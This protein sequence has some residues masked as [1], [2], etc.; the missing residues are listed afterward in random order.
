MR[1]SA[2]CFAGHWDTSHLEPQ[3]GDEVVDS[4]GTQVAQAEPLPEEVTSCLVLRAEQ[5]TA[6][7]RAP[8]QW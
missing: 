1:P 3:A 6:L 8:D 7:P 2:G 5:E 4:A